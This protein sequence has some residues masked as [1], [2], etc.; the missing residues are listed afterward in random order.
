MKGLEAH[1]YLLGDKW[2]LPCPFCG[3]SAVETRTDDNGISWY[4]FCNDC[5]LIAGYSTTEEDLI[6]AWNSRARMEEQE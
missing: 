4:V 5:G 1:K 2:L 6:G 3:G